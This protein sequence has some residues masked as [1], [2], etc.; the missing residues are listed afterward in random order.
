MASARREFSAR[1]ACKNKAHETYYYYQHGRR[2]IKAQSLL[3]V[4]QS[5]QRTDGNKRS[6]SFQ[7]IIV[8]AHATHAAILPLDTKVSIFRVFNSSLKTFSLGFT[9]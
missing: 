3:C 2:V 8:F 7:Y 4:I 6:T 1:L 9:F 5:S